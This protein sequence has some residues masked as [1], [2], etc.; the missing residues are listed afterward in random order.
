VAPPARED[1]VGER[2]RQMVDV[3]LAEVDSA[4]R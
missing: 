2:P 4:I 3:A 1:C